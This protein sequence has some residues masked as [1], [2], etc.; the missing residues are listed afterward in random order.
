MPARKSALDQ[1]RIASPCT[2]SWEAMD[3]DDT[4]RHCARCDRRVHDLSAMSGAAIADLL[5]REPDA[6]GR[7]H[8]RAD[9]TVITGD[10]PV[11][12][13]RLRRRRWSVAGV[14]ALLGGGVALLLSMWPWTTGTPE[15]PDDAGSA[16]T[17]SGDPTGR[18]RSFFEGEPVF[19]QIGQIIAPTPPAPPPG[20][21]TP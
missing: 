5:A 6:C 10:C 18:Q 4:S 7:L 13:R 16:A 2:A 20:G 3:G 14:L 17:P 15:V 11:G 21:G 1:L 12:A 8:R 9:G 19:I